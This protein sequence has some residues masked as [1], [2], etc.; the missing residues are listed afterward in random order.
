MHCLPNIK[1]FK[2]VFVGPEACPVDLPPNALPVVDS[3]HGYGSCPSCTNQGR[4]RFSAL[5]GFTYQEFHNRYLL[6]QNDTSSDVGN[7]SSF[8]KP[9]LIVAFNTGM[10][11]EHEEHIESWK[12]CLEIIMDTN[13]P[14]FF[15]SY[16]LSEAIQDYA[17]LD[18]AGANLLYKDGPKRNPFCSQ[19][20]RIDMDEIGVDSFYQISMHCMSFKGRK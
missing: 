16:S 19:I 12:E 4:E 9:D 3:G 7:P 14:A 17:V 15:T 2:T 1:K 6:K 18:G 5:Y 8:L 10:H 11:E 13:V 20:A